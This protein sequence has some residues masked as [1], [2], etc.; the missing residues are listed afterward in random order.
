MNLFLNT[1]EFIQGIAYLRITL[2]RELFEEIKKNR[3]FNYNEDLFQYKLPTD[4]LEGEIR[5]IADQIKADGLLP[6]SEVALKPEQWHILEVSLD[7]IKIKTFISLILEGQV[8]GSLSKSILDFTQKKS[9]AGSAISN[10]IAATIHELSSYL[11]EFSEQNNLS[12]SNFQNLLARMVSKIGGSTDKI[13]LDS[14]LANYLIQNE[15]PFEKDRTIYS[16]KVSYLANSW[17]VSVTIS[18]SKDML[19]LFSY[20]S[21]EGSSIIFESILEELEIINQELTFGKFELDLDNRHL[22][23]K[24]ENFINL[25]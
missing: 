6:R 14:E 4:F 2:S 15:I 22:L 24:S 3:W 5:L 10:E 19:I 20:V 25:F 12:P 8:A 7:G 9:L 16:F 23:L 1:V 11:V 18:E 21:I 17:E 13:I